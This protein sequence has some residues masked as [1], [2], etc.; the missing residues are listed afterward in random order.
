MGHFGA[1][2]AVITGASGRLGA[3]FAQTLAGRGWRVAL[4]ARRTG[5]LERLA[6]TISAAGGQ[7]SLFE[8]DISDVA[9]IKAAFETIERSIGPISVLVNNAGVSG[10]GKALEIDAATFDA[11]FAVNVRGAFFAARCMI[12]SGAA[13]SGVARIINIA[14]IA[15]YQSLPGLGA[16]CSSKAALVALTKAL[17]REWA[18]EGIAVNA[19]CPGFIETEMNSEWF[20]S[21][22][23]RKQKNAFPRRRLVPE[24]ALDDALLLLAGPSARYV[25]GAAITIDDG[26][27]L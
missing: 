6:A 4:T 24:E 26:Q 20:A 27:S 10:A 25:T 7:A 16:Y 9:A 23:G 18:R 2:V 8:L 17:A 22:G 11:T 1:P 12:A 13:A 21:D 14:S 15:A 19:I 3:R 5:R